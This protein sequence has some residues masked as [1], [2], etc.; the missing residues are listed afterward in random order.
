MPA[1]LAGDAVAHFGPVGA[2]AFEVAVLEID[3]GGAVG[4]CGEEDFDVAGFGGVG[5]VLPGGVDFP[6]DDQ[7]AW[8]V[9][10]GDF[11]PGAV[12]AVFLLG[13]AAAADA[14]FD[15]GALH[16]GFADVVG[17][18]PPTVEVFGENVEGVLLIGFDGDGAVD[19]VFGLASERIGGGAHFFAPFFVMREF[20]LG[21]LLRCA[22]CL[23]MEISL[24]GCF[25][26]GR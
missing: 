6:G 9:P 14:A 2:E 15:D 18:G 23:G 19:D 25:R 1:A 21:T 8:R 11:A 5:F 3:A 13:V 17:A 24:R 7:A 16:G 22:G 12:G 26:R 10:L 20:F 4:E